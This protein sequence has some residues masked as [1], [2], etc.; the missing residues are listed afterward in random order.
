M[1][2]KIKIFIWRIWMNSLPTLE[3]L[4][5][6]KIVKISICPLCGSGSED[7]MHTIRDCVLVK[8]VYQCID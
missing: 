7:F 6:R 4:A 2:N 5:R 3:N 8:F 1:P